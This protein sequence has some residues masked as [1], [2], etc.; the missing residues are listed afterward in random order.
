ML[1]L[2]NRIS[3][4]DKLEKELKLSQEKKIIPKYEFTNYI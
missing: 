3:E 4:K 1:V 2:L